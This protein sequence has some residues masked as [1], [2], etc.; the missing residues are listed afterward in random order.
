MTRARPSKIS[1]E[2][3][4]AAV[5]H[6]QNLRQLLLALGVAAYGGNDEVI[7]PRLAELGVDDPRF[8]RR[9]RQAP[10][11]QVPVAELRRAT[12]IADSFAQV[13]RLLG[14]GEGV[15]V[16]RRA[17]RLVQEAGPDT[18]HFLGRSAMR[19][20]RAGGRQ[21]EPWDKLLVRG[22]RLN[23]SGL[24]ACLLAEGLLQRECAECLLEEWQGEPIPLELDH[25]NGDR[26]DNRLE[27]LRLFC[28]NC[29]AQTDTYRGRNI[30]GPRVM[31][32][33]PA[34]ELPV[35]AARRRLALV[36]AQADAVRS[37]ARP[38]S[39]TG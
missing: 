1:D 25:V 21:P 36:L 22:R 12:A 31:E 39:P 10:S 4:L 9:P 35:V 33:G 37:A 24:R 29:H 14:F 23:T 15:T 38:C 20:A 19:G 34:R 11:R 6:A 8:A 28:P 30:G 2:Q 18:S 5:P 26:L 7:R 32:P 27:N 16:Q 17:R 13:A 3:L